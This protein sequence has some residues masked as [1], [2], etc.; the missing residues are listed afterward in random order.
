MFPVNMVVKSFE[1]QVIGATGIQPYPCNGN[2]L[3][4]EAKEAIKKLRPGQKAFFD[5][6]K[7]QTPTGI[8][9]LPMAQIKLKS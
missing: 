1:L 6:V 8:I 4:A 5:N 9:N 2:N 3:S 7:V